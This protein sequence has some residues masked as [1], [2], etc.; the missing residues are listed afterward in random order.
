MQQLGIFSPARERWIWHDSTAGYGGHTGLLSEVPTPIS[1]GIPGNTQGA[2][3]PPGRARLEA[4]LIQVCRQ[5]PRGLY[6]ISLRP[7]V[8]HLQQKKKNVSCEYFLASRLGMTI[9]DAEPRL[10]GFTSSGH[11]TQRSWWVP[12]DVADTLSTHWPGSESGRRNN[13]W[14]RMSS[15]F[16]L[17]T[18]THW[19][20]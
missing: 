19:I 8:L 14:F 15:I 2:E 11:L 9:L 5:K 6:P 3:A 18:C 1:S 16:L 13:S 4:L 7:L 20:L 12:R 17:V 10:E